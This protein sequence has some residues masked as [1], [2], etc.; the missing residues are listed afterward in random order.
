[1]PRISIAPMRRTV[2]PQRVAAVDLCGAS[3]HA[4]ARMTGD[5]YGCAVRALGGAPQSVSPCP[6]CRSTSAR[7]R[8][9]VEGIDAPVVVC[10]SCKLGR[11]HPML[12]TERIAALYP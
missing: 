7:A 11:F 1:M 10:E 9:A 8:F 3:A 5:L 2:A 6:V 12:T 4:R